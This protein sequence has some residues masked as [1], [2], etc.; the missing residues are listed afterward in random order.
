VNILLASS[1]VQPFAK[2][3]GLGDV[4][5]ALPKALSELG[6]NVVI[7][8]PAFRTVFKTNAR[9][10]PTGHELNIPI[11]SKIVHGRLLQTVLPG[12]SV[13]VYLVDQP[14]YFDRNGF[15]G[16]NGED[17]PDNCERFIFFCR[18]VLESIRT[19]KLDVDLIHCND[20]Q[21][22]LIPAYV[23]IEY[24]KVPHY[25]KI[26]TLMTIHN[27]AYQGWFWHWDMALTGLDW[28]Y[29]N[30]RQLE[31]Y[32]QLNLMK[33]GIV[34]A[35][36]VNTVSEKYAEEIQTQEFG[37]GLEGVLGEISD[38]LSG[39][40]NG[41]DYSEWN[42]ATDSM[43]AKNYDV[44]TWKSGKAVC[45]SDLQSK[46][47]LPVRNDVPLIGLVGRLAE[48]KGWNLV[49]ELMKS[50]T[51]A[52]DVQW[53]ILGSG[54]PKYEQALTELAHRWP[55]KIAAEIGFSNELAHQIEA[56]TD[57]FLMPSQYEP[58]GLN[59]MY[60]LKYGTVPIVHATGGLADT[61]TH[62][63][64]ENLQRGVAN[65]FSFPHFDFEHFKSAARQ[66]LETY[67]QRPD[68]WQSIVETGMR[69]DWSWKN[70]AQKYVELYEQTVQHR[71]VL[72]SQTPL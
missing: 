42:P 20:W 10:E 1:E 14:E 69:Q 3:G 15:Y 65:G 59:Q 66:A 32:D 16:E 9:I 40:I 58:C 56:G 23:E 62:A 6:H 4:C 64:E 22:G 41:V 55:D 67:R 7:F 54:E 60:S 63:S 45:K 61:I 51:P 17:Y 33:A 30:Y 53:A 12:S 18:A 27:L 38:N 52:V 2:T 68:L 11:G 57:M 43:I 31:F 44:E 35:D 24:R 47:K 13:R 39:I 19:L 70:S 5:S 50:W 48:Q 8:L 36:H 28:K 25:E 21:T 29:F 26:A 37:C 46:L 34:F 72:K 71:L 49:I